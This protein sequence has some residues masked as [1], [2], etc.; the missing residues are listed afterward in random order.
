MLTWWTMPVSGGTTWKLLNASLAPAEERVA[1][2][3]AREL[4]LRVQRER[5][6]APEVVHLHRVVDD[7]LDRLQRVDAIGVAAER[8]DRVAHG[9]QIDH[10]RHAGEVLQ[11]DARRHEGDLLL[12]VGRGVPLG[13][14]A[15]VVGLDEG[16]VLAPQQVLEQDLHRVRQARRRRGIRPS[17][18]PEG[19][20]YWNT[21]APMRS[22]VRVLKLFKVG[23]AGCVESVF[24]LRCAQ[25]EVLP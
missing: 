15:D 19:C 1:L 16:V 23:M 4:E 10:A 22:S 5:V 12:D 13:E 2:A 11:Q 9:R 25:S 6:G 18:A 14:R 17:R 8:D 24:G 7:E 20:R 21:S 3:V